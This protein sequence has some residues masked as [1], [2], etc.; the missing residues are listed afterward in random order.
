MIAVLTAITICIDGL[1]A[2]T[3]AFQAAN[4]GSNPGR[5]IS[6]GNISKRRN[7]SLFCSGYRYNK[8]Q[9]VKK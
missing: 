7:V 9:K 2:M 3:A 6:K 4:P 8:F 1:V 5:C